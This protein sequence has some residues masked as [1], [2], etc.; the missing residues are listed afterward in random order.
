MK[1]GDVYRMYYRGSSD[2]SYT[3]KSQL[4]PGEQITAAHPQYA[5][6]AESRD[7]ITWTRPSLGLFEFNGS[8][9]NNIVWVRARRPQPGGVQRRES[10][11]ARGRKVQGGR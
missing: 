3:M 2:P 6:Y 11:R 4:R 7:G 5:C 9:D 8:K 1:D 10:G